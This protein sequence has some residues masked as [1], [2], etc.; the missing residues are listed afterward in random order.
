MVQETKCKICGVIIPKNRYKFC[1]D[2][3]AL[4]YKKNKRNLANK[5]RRK[6]WRDLDD[7]VKLDIMV[8]KTKEIMSNL[9]AK[10]GGRMKIERLD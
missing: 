10:D 1:S 5:K 3:C 6:Q 9:E 7:S 8:E 2:S 4:R